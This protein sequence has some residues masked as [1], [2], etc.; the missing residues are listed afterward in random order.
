ML[1]VGIT[2]GIGSGKSIVCEIFKKLGI[3]VYNAD[4]EAKILVN[5]DA[6]VRKQLIEIFG[7]E[8]YTNSGEINKIKLSSIIFKDKN[9]LQKVNS[10]VHPV[11]KQHYNDWLHDKENCKYVIKE[12]AKTT[13]R[14]LTIEEHN[15]VNGLGSAVAEVI[16]ESNLRTTFKRLALPDQ[17]T[18]AGPYPELQKYYSLDSEGIAD[19]ARNML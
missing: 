8:I 13:D 14:I 7:D 18:L 16:A 17:Y 10:I 19:T 9:A 15:I 1:K 3:S 12:A 11:V 6:N 2:G 5:S 4:N